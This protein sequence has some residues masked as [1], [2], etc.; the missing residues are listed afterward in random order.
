MTE[1]L[2]LRDCYLRE[3]EAEIIDVE[4]NSAELSKTAFYPEGGGQP[5][6]EG[7]LRFKDKNFEVLKVRKEKSRILHELSEIPPSIGTKVECELNWDLRY[8]HMRHH[9]ALHILSKVVYDEFGASITGN[10]IHSDRARMDFAHER[11]DPEKLDLV[12]ERANEIVEKGIPIKIHILE[13][14]EALKIVDP[15][16]TRIDMIPSFVKEIRLIE[17]EGLDMEAC[18][19]TH[20]RNTKEVGK[21]KIKRYINKG[22]NNKRLE[23]ALKK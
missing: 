10:Q 15:K 11:W 9:T 3:F 23:I 18:G 13:R 21:L 6:D 22:K 19:G 20:L 1:M 8:A 5:S 17:I 2:Y 7:I 4:G 14:E 12:Q 16:R